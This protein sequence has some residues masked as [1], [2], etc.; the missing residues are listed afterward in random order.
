[1]ERDLL[2][3]SEIPFL[4][5]YGIQAQRA[6]EDHRICGILAHSRLICAMGMI[7]KG[8]ASANLKLKLSEARHSNAIQRA[9]QEMIE[10]KWNYEFVVDVYQARLAFRFR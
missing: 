6:I 2:G 9:A 5:Y 8:T 7:E 10:G 1:L 4:A 3:Q